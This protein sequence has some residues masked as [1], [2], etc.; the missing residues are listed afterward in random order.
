[1]LY[2]Q[3][4]PLNRKLKRMFIVSVSQ[5]R[6]EKQHALQL[7]AFAHARDLAS[8]SDAYDGIMCARL[9]LVGGCRGEDDE[10][11]VD[12]LKGVGWWGVNGSCCV[13]FCPPRSLVVGSVPQDI[14]LVK[15][16]PMPFCV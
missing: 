16:T 7:R 5:F 9:K 8:D 11:R 10:R 4:L 13:L 14:C 6:P 15:Q 12:D 2:L 1:M 3:E